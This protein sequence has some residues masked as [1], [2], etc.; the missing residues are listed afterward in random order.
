MNLIYILDEKSSL[1]LAVLCFLAIL[2]GQVGFEPQF[3]GEACN[4]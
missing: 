4:L 1:A 3:T 2:S